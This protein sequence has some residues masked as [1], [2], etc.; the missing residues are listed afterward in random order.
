MVRSSR[1]RTPVIDLTLLRIRAFALSNGVTVVMASGFYAYT[2]CNVLFLTTV[3][4][5]S[6]LNA[7]LALMPGPFVAM[8][9][10]G[11]ASRAVERLGHRA[12]LVPG[13]LVWAGGMLYFATRLGVSPDF[14]GEWLAGMVILGIG[15]GM[16]FPTLSGA[17]VGSVPGPRFAVATSL[18]SVARQV[19][20]ALGVAILIAIIGKPTPAQAL[21][22]FQHGW[23]FAG[24]CF[25]AGSLACLALVVTRPGADAPEVE[26]DRIAAPAQG[27]DP[28]D[29]Q[30]GVPQLPSLA[31]SEG[32]QAVVVAQSVA[33]FLRNVP[34]FAALSADDAGADRR[35]GERRQPAP[36]RVA[37]PRGR[38][39]GRGIRRA[40]RPPRGDPGRTGV[41][42]RSTRS[43]A[44]R[45]S[46][47]SRCSATRCAAPRFARCATPSS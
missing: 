46:G 42:R 41:R 43:L 10:A 45:C 24:G 15:A 21:H 30:A 20:A 38:S 36:W 40:G 17:A 31:E 6:I 23:L 13:A 39:G 33:E 32:E 44:G 29:R 18:N 47:S 5:Y 3:W 7:G 9:V 28:A 37:V 1:Q 25:L 19:G 4:R 27:E 2:L 8:A 12:I 16:T 26:S 14:L 11:P 34:V 35:A 22:V